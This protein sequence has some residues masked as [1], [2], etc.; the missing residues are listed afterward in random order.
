MGIV[1]RLDRR[2]SLLGN[3]V[4]DVRSAHGGGYGL[5]VGEKLLSDSHPVPCRLSEA[6]QPHIAFWQA[7]VWPHPVSLPELSLAA[8]LP[9]GQ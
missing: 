4:V 7:C 9:A 3:V 1:G 5:G 8:M 6:A 2:G